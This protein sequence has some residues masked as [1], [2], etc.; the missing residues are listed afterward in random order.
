MQEF[1]RP[2]TPEQ[3]A[4]IESYHSIITSAVCN[5]F[6]FENLSHAQEVFIRWES[7]YNDER[8]HSGIEYKSPKKYLNQHNIILPKKFI[9][10]EIKT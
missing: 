2:A 10:M 7:F 3:N 5:R 9:S 6:E 1:T 4:H 8:I